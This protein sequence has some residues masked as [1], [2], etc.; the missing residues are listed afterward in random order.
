MKIGR[1]RRSGGRLAGMGL[2]LLLAAGATAWF[3]THY[4]R[5]EVEVTG[6]M[7]AAARMNPL[8]A[9]DRFLA[10]LGIPVESHRGRDLLVSLPPAGDALVV[11]HMSGNLTPSQVDALDGW[12]REGGHLVVAPPSFTDDGEEPDST[13]LLGRQGVLLRRYPETDD[14][15]CDGEAGS[16]GDADGEPDAGDAPPEEKVREQEGPQERTA[17]AAQEQAEEEPVRATIAGYSVTLDPPRFGYL[18]DSTETASLA[19]ADSRG[20]GAVLLDYRI[21]AGRLTVLNSMEIFTNREIGSRDHGFLLA[22]LVG[23]DR[24]T[25]LLFSS[26]MDG[27]GT[28]LWRWQAPFLVGLAVL[29]ALV[30]WTWQYRIGPLEKEENGQRRRNVLDHIDATGRYSWRIDRA[31]SLLAANRDFFIRRWAARHAGRA[32]ARVDLA[33][34]AARTGMTPDEV[35]TALARTVRTEQDLV[36]ASH[37]LQRLQNRSTALSVSDHGHRIF[38]R[39]QP[40]A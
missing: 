21:G 32:G 16:A 40:D 23:G 7:S 1:R 12:I 14:C 28:L 9:A 2:V 15:G 13:D 6:A 25:W 4:E 5:K 17:A 38:T 11:L 39:S 19:I 37:W 24:K 27:I 35:E 26:N 33:Q 34:I 10:G 3:F 8:L 31:A 18:E 20:R 22:W 30:A 36:A 29:L